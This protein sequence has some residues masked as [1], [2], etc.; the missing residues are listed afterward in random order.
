M[1]TKLIFL[2]CLLITLT[3]CAPAANKDYSEHER[4]TVNLPEDDSVNGYRLPD[5]GS[6]DSLSVPAQNGSVS[7]DTK[8]ESPAFSEPETPT[9]KEESYIGN[10]ST[11]V[12]HRADCG[13]VKTM[14]DENKAEFP[15]REAA[16]DE[17]YTPCK[18]CKP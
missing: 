15:D 6:S 14:K 17:G 12:L 18:R 1:K 7:A 10:K 11:H 16:L 13:S 4:V 2:L 8:T 3:A 9:P 5:D